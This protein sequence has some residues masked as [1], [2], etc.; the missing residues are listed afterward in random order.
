MFL[1]LDSSFD[2][3]HEFMWPKVVD[4]FSDDFPTTVHETLDT[5]GIFPLEFN[6]NFM[7]NFIRMSKGKGIVTTMDFWSISMFDKQL[8]V[9]DKLNNTLPIQVVSV[10]GE[11]T[12]GYYIKLSNAVRNSKQ[13]V[14]LINLVRILDRDFCE[15]YI[16][17]VLSKVVCHTVQHVQ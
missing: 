8:R 1:F 3:K 11:A 10:G 13:R 17:G 16:E 6:A 12:R 14:Y 4:L 5:N 15:E 9:L 7:S 2:Y